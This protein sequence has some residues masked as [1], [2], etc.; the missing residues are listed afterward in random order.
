[1]CEIKPHNS[2]P[3]KTGQYLPLGPFCR[4]VIWSGNNTPQRPGISHSSSSVHSDSK[5]ALISFEVNCSAKCLVSETLISGNLPQD[6][7]YITNCYFCPMLPALWRPCDD[8]LCNKVAL[9]CCLYSSNHTGLCWE[10]DAAQYIWN[11]T[12]IMKAPQVL[13]YPQTSLHSH[14]SLTS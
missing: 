14:S 11:K 6:S 4:W 1:M 2:C 9:F 7:W 3:F 12:E 8:C 5:I 13:T 10:T